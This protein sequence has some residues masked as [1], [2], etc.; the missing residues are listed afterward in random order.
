M[1]IALW[2]ASGLLALAM[3]A[4]GGLKLAVPREKLLEKMSWAKTWTDERFKLLGLA[5]VLG[6][7]GVV[8]PFA[9]GIVPVLTPIAALCLVVLMLGAAKTHVDLGEAPRAAPPVFLAALGVFVALGRF[10]LLP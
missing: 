7:V 4:A 2:I 3:V 8:V 9:T 5:E 1:S 6:G 10:G